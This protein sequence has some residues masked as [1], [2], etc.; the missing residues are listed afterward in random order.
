MRAENTA[1]YEILNH[2]SAG[3]TFAAVKPGLSQSA[4]SPK[5]SY[6]LSAGDDS[7]INFGMRAACSDR[8]IKIFLLTL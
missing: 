7:I 8:G 5:S 4:F 6:I 1:N 3:F 2:F